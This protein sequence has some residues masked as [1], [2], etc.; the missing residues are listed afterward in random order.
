MD[1]RLFTGK[2]LAKI[3]WEAGI[4]RENYFCFSLGQIALVIK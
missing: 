2:A 1:L 4:S 3:R